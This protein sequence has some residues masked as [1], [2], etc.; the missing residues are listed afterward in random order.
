MKVK[1]Y[2]AGL[3]QVTTSSFLLTALS[4]LCLLLKTLQMITYC[5][6][7]KMVQKK[8]DMVSLLLN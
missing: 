6:L 8:V 5:L 3:I 7:L 4:L 2:P 1:P